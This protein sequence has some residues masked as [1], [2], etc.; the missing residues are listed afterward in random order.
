MP[1]SFCP[2]TEEWYELWSWAAGC[3]GSELDWSFTVKPQAISSLVNICSNYWKTWTLLIPVHWAD[4][5]RLLLRAARFRGRFAVTH[6]HFLSD[7]LQSVLQELLLLRHHRPTVLGGLAVLWGGKLR[8]KLLLTLCSA[9]RGHK[10]N[11]GVKQVKFLFCFCFVP[12]LWFY[13]SK[14][15]NWSWTDKVLITF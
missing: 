13:S 10:T 6:L 1:S 9:L 4:L 2:L 12:C 3:A 15:W 8:V 7:V 14:F 11:A 5:I